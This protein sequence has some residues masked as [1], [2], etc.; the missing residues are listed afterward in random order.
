MWIGV[1]SQV[2]KINYS[3]Y[4]MPVMIFQP[5]PVAILVS[6]SVVSTHLK[7]CLTLIISMWAVCFSR[8]W[9]MAV[10]K[11]S[12][13]VLVYFSLCLMQYS[14]PWTTPW[15]LYT[16]PVV[17][18]EVLPRSREKSWLCKKKFEF[19][20]MDFRLRS[21][22]AVPHHFRKNESSIRTIVQKEK[23]ICKASAAAMPAGVKNLHFYSCIENAAFM[24]VQD[25][26][27]KGV[28]MHTLHSFS[29]VCQLY[30]NKMRR[31]KMVYL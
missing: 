5:P 27:K 6:L 26:Y 7:C 16:V 25:Y 11:W 15:D 29:A 10:K 24:W 12:L 14:K 31:E 19:L 1:K 22:A 23:E 17:L 3:L 28:P 30:L 18:L 13:M 2:H 9:C 8:K 4:C 21:A 20:G